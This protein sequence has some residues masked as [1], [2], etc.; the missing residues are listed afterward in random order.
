[1]NASVL[2]DASSVVCQ[3]P[4]AL[5]GIPVWNISDFNCP[6]T[7]LS[8][9][10]EN[11]FYKVGLPVMLLC[12]VL[13]SFLLL[14]LLLWKVKQDKKQVQPGKE[15]T[16]ENSHDKLT[17]H[18]SRMTERLRS[19]E[20][21][22]E[23]VQTTVKIDK[24]QQNR[25][26]KTRAKSASPIMLRTEFQHSSS[27]H[28][29]PTDGNQEQPKTSCIVINEQAC[30]KNEDFNNVMELWYFNS[31]QDCN[32][33]AMHSHNANTS[34]T[35]LSIETPQ[36]DS[37]ELLKQS[38]QDHGIS[39][40]CWNGEIKG[41]GDTENAEP[42]LYLS[43][44][45]TTEESPSVPCT[46]QK[47]AVSRNVN[48]RLCS[49]RRV[50]TWPYEKCKRAQSQN[51]LNYEDFF[52]AHFCMPT[53]DPGFPAAVRKTEFKDE[54][55]QYNLHLHTVKEQKAI[56]DYSNGKPDLKREAKP[57]NKLVSPLKKGAK[58]IATV[59]NACI[60]VPGNGFRGSETVKKN[61]N[62]KDIPSQAGFCNDDLDSPTSSDKSG[63]TSSP[64]DDTLLKNNEYTFIDLL[65]EVV[66]NLLPG[67]PNSTEK[68]LLRHGN[69]SKIPPLS[70]QNFPR[71]HLLSITGFQFSSLAN[72]TFVAKDVSS[73]RSLDLSSNCLLSCGIEPLAFSGLGILE[74]LSLTNN[75][76]DTLKS[77]WFLE[78]TLLTKLLLSDNKITYL[79]P[80][81]FESLAKLN[82]LIVSSNFIQYLSMDTFY[83][84]PSLTKLDLSSNEILF[85]ND[86]VFQP[87]QALTHLWLF[88]NKLTALAS[89]PDSL[90]SLSL[91]ENPWTCTCHLVSSM[92]LLKEKV[93]TPSG[94]VCNSPPSLK[95]RHMLSVGPEVCAFP[96]RTGNL[97]QE[98][99]SK[100][101]TLYGFTGGLFF[102]FIMC[103]I[104]Y[105][106]TKHWKYSR[107]TNQAE[108]GHVLQE[109]SVE[110]FPR[111]MTN[112]PS[113]SPLP[114]RCVRKAN[115]TRAFQKESEADTIEK[116]LCDHLS[117]ASESSREHSET[118]S[119]VKMPG[120][121]LL[122][123]PQ[124][125]RS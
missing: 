105:F 5:K 41:S 48:M 51:T 21:S 85:I 65:H 114:H 9:S 10:L 124:A 116:A 57:E 37:S 97:P 25:M 66:E 73:L 47:G 94:L 118:S 43:V 8:P 93:Q 120:V 45:S 29:R 115:R 82:E 91:N 112:A 117:N 68:I 42:L 71:L 22:D 39:E 64:C 102:S 23:K 89:M 17:G 6:P 87:L 121:A 86:D 111:S 100:F 3:S 56:H 96:T 125:K 110:E 44:A 15:A 2:E 77:F 78:M 63:H 46:E 31:L 83:G 79:P 33:A 62:N 104:V 11:D 49:L 16:V 69:L 55:N 119:P 108:D 35:E 61:K 80:R 84:L 76:L 53:G 12:L 34:P 32:K 72:L 70:F 4:Q 60:S 67:L 1:M 88:K 40:V 109:D 19:R 7:P 28:H 103:L 26:Q 52:K 30:M 14:L 13:F 81:T 113:V 106:I 59:E 27:Q 18:V 101:N 90:T 92:Q 58:Q 20:L 75:A 99:T 54:Q 38:L 74:E 98:S 50:L 24:T 95:G 36:K 107:V 122:P 123:V